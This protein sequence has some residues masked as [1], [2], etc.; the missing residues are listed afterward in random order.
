M[1]CWFVS[2]IFDMYN[3]TAFILRYSFYPCVY[4]RVVFNLLYFLLHFVRNNKNKGYQ[5][6]KFG[7]FWLLIACSAPR[8]CFNQYSLYCRLIPWEHISVAFRLTYH[9]IQTTKCAWK[10]SKCRKNRGYLVPTS[11]CLSHWGRDVSKTTFSNAFLNGNIW[12]LN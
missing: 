3:L 6:R 12:I 4:L 5:S 7:R 10:C 1:A 11:T 8:R 9:N 2:T